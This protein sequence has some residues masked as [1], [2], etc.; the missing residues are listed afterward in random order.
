MIS[1]IPAINQIVS[2]SF[3]VV[4]VIL[5]IMLF[6]CLLRACLGPTVADRLVSIN[7]MG[8]IVIV[9][10]AILAIMMNEGY[11]ADISLIYAMISFLAV[12]V[13]SKVIIGIHKEQALNDLTT[14][15]DEL[16]E[17]GYVPEPENEKAE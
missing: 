16:C 7:M 17:T 12:I 4:L 14:D 2:I 11:L 9:I 5:S 13:L 3:T 15:E 8:T 1:S 10:I 6:F